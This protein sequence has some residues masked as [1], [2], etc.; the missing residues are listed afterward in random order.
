MMEDAAAKGW[1]LRLEGC[2]FWKGSSCGMR[3]AQFRA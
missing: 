1:R 3:N 2:R